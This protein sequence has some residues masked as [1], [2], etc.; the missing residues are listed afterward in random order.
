MSFLFPEAGTSPHSPSAALA[1]R[2]N[3]AE[4]ILIIAHDRDEESS[5]L[6]PAQQYHTGTDLPDLTI[7]DDTIAYEKILHRWYSGGSVSKQNLV[8]SC[9]T[10]STILNRC[11]RY[12]DRFL[13]CAASNLP[14]CCKRH[15][16]YLALRAADVCR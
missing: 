16:T 2:A 10:D 11:W 5:L 13:C 12:L 8:T 3:N 6:E 7:V 4:Q 14:L 15:V 9:A 1:P